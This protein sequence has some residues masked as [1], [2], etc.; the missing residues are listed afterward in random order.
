MLVQH[1]HISETVCLRVSCKL[2]LWG[3]IFLSMA[4]LVICMQL[5]F[6]FHE[7]Q[8]R[9]RRHQNYRRVVSSME[10]RWAA[11]F[12]QPISVLTAAEPQL[13]NFSLQLHIDKLY[14]ILVNSVTSRHVGHR[15]FYFGFGLVF[16]N[17]LMFGSEWVWFGS[18]RKCGSVWYYS[19][20]LVV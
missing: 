8:R 20:S 3:N 12:L 11:V 18:V 4:S 5:R 7:L 2:Q 14:S 13:V 1:L 16:L 10:A 9:I 15:F 19:Y 17:K 6:L